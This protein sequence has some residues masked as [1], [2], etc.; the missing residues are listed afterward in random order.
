MKKGRGKNKRKSGRK[1]GRRKKKTAKQLN[2]PVY[3]L[4][5]LSRPLVCHHGA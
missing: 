2:L 1:K 4:D 5:L 3:T